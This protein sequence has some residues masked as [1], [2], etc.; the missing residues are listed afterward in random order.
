M[1][2]AKSGANRPAKP[3]RI[4]N[5][6]K[7]PLPQAVLNLPK[8]MPGLSRYEF[9]ADGSVKNKA[10]G[11]SVNIATT[12]RVN[13]FR[14]TNDKGVRIWVYPEQIAELFKPDIKSKALVKPSA[15]IRKD[16]ERK[17]YNRLPA[18]DIDS[19][20]KLL[21]KD[22]NLP[23]G[24]TSELARKFEVNK[25]TISRIVNQETRRKSYFKS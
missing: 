24:M 10:T 15:Y 11:N 6:S 18:A 12:T 7:Q 22:G 17:D 8:N 5:K 3:I 21:D 23:R 4:E 25:S 19:I 2:K 9:Y 16:P 14:L 20:L 1:A 13:G